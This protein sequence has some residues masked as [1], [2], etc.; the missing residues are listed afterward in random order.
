MS[1][2]LKIKTASGILWKLFE[3]IGAQLVS[4]IVSIIIA[5]I[6]TPSDYSVVSLVTIFFTFANVLIS[7]GLNTALIQKKDAD[8]EDYSSV[9]IVSV[10][11]SLVIYL[12]LFITA[13][14][15]ANAYNVESITV[16]IRVMG[17]A[18]P[19][20]AVKSIWCAYISSTLQFKKFFFATL[21]GTIASAVVGILLAIKGVGPWALVAQQ[22][23][24]TIIDTIILILTTRL[25]L[26]FR[27][28][29]QK[30]KVLIKYGWK[31]LFSSLIGTTYNSIV[32]LAIGLKYT[33]QDLSFYT[34]GNSF[35]SL[36][37]TTTTNTLSAVLF[38][39][40]AKF[41]DDKEKLLKYT[42]LFIRL[43][44]FI[45]FP[46]MLG[47]FAVADKFVLVILTE[48][49]ID[50]V[51]YIKI[52]CIAYMFE[53]IHVGNCETIKAMGRSDIYL[54]MEIIK[55]VGYFL[56]IGLFLIFTNTPQQLALAFWVCTCIALIVN[57][58][59]NQI[60]LGYKF[61]YQLLD[62]LP[63]L[64]TSIIMCVI[65]SFIGKLNLNIYILLL[66]Q[67]LTGIVVYLLLNI[68]IKNSSLLY[69]V[70]FIKE[71]FKK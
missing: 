5:R 38:P 18:L 9:L 56:T 39:T 17:L 8:M 6:L 19:I 70:N 4:L 1:N 32:P 58:I 23:T 40:L 25:K 14:Y 63:N 13:P 62:I 16:I 52:F 30:L 42:R 68:I 55:K 51:P 27:I 20:T 46:M 26:M 57:S 60:L 31:I 10:A 50:A 7:G 35:P 3:R 53:M 48:K 67:V 59:P 21:G 44:S 54:V 41:Q 28:S 66:L 12:I 2:D 43:A 69:I 22:M 47:F 15:I 11:F 33:N 29:W 45:A 24:N 61:K 64:V 37:S 49:W 65:V 36:I 71:R 34:K